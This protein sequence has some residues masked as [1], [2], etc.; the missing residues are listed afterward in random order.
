MKCR[1]WRVGRS[2]VFISG[3]G[4]RIP[5]VVGGWDGSLLGNRVSEYGMPRAAGACVTDGHRNPFCLEPGSPAYVPM[6][7]RKEASVPALL[8]QTNTA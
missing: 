4:T 7:P 1:V 8:I 3:D 2:S 6:T 5:N